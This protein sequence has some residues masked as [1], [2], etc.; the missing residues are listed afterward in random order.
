MAGHTK[1]FYPLCL[2]IFFSKSFA[3]RSARWLFTHGRSEEGKEVI[4]QIA[5]R[6]RRPE[7]NFENLNKILKEEEEKE[8]A[9]SMYTYLS[10]FK[11][12]STR[13]TTL[14]LSFCW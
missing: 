5:K 6:N 1:M 13:K 7:P 10:L 9:N 12:P 8:R 14:L 4:R 11:F 3:P 2:F